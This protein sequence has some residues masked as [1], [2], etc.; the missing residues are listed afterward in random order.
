MIKMVGK[1]YKF[2]L[3]QLD[4]FC[5]VADQIII[6]LKSVEG[7]KK[8]K[9][10]FQRNI[11]EKVKNIKTRILSIFQTRLTDFSGKIIRIIRKCQE[12]VCGNVQILFKEPDQIQKKRHQK[13]HPISIYQTR[14]T[15]FLDDAIS[16]VKRKIRLPYKTKPVKVNKEYITDK[17]PDDQRTAFKEYRNFHGYLGN[18]FTLNPSL[19]NYFMNLQLKS[20][21]EPQ[22]DSDFLN[23][24]NI[25]KLEVARCK[26]GRP[27][28]N[29]WIDEINYNESLRAELGIESKLKL[30]E[31]SYKR[32]LEI[33]SLSLNEYADI[34]KQECRDLNLIRDMLWIWDRRFF[35]CNCSGIK[36]KQTGKFSDPDAGHYVKK[37]GKY[38]VLT[39]TGYTDTG[40]V[41][42]LW[43]LPVYWGAVGANKN[44][45]TIFKETVIDGIKCIKSPAK[46]PILIM[47]DAGPDSH[48]SNKLVHEYG[49]IPIIAARENSV[50]EI[51]KTDEGDCFRGE[52]IP[53]EYHRML[54]RLYDLRTIIE[55]KNS[56]EVVGY[57]RSEMP[58]RGI[59]WARCFVSVSNITA[60]LTALTAC[61]VGRYDLIRAP[62]AFRRLSV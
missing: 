18:I 17:L 37:T 15:D 39:G 24:N 45:N 59:D 28:F 7:R 34:L 3:K 5:G 48:D 35:E 10:V 38:S 6:S 44:D 2:I 22:Q 30:N 21:Y 56:N 31:R 42:H 1:G 40:F 50:G 62:S 13:N 33:V 23:L 19:D 58:N 43:G 41:D 4:D 61:K 14:L 27:H 25:F 16:F 51:I 29:S 47:S 11:P 26:L 57:N 32:N 12:I 8:Y 9:E 52:Y 46:K 20:E 54:G 55:R 49:I 60:L 36:N 53:R